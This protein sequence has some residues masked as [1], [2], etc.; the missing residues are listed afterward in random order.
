MS[1]I[2]R[3]E[4]DAARLRKQVDGLALTP[5]LS[6]SSIDGGALELRDDVGNTTGYVGQQY[7]GTW[8]VAPVG[9]TYPVAPNP[10]LVTPIQG[11]LR[12]YWDGTYEDDSTTRSDFRRVAFLGVPL[13]DGPDT[14]DPL[15]PGQIIGEITIATGGEITVALPP[16][17]YLIV[18]ITW[19]ESGKFSVESDIATGTPLTLI[20][21]AEWQQHEEALEQLNNVDVP[22]LKDA[23][24]ELATTTGTLES[25]L[26]NLADELAQLQ[27]DAGGIGEVSDLV[28]LINRSTSSRHG[29]Y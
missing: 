20:D 29:I 27:I 11:G 24:E 23:T 4:R 3:R 6:R 22:A 17:E 16:V 26:S 14:L 1:S 8:G 10:P 12:I 2:Q 13:A 7:D 21:D 5:R 28:A 18:G 25:G 9:G 15:N 19:T